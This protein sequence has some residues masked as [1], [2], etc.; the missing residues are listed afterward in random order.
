ML[1]S[2]AGGGPPSTC[3]GL[4]AEGTAMTGADELV[5]V[6]VEIH[7]AP[8]VRA[9][10]AEGGEGPL[11]GTHDPRRA[12]GRR[13]AEPTRPTDLEGGHRA[14]RCHP[15]RSGR[16]VWTG[17]VRSSLSAGRR[18]SC[19]RGLAGGAANAVRGPG[20][21]PTEYAA[22][23]GCEAAQQHRQQTRGQHNSAFELLR[24]QITGRRVVSAE[25]R[26]ALNDPAV[27]GTARP[28][29]QPR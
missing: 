9:H 4:G 13:V 20:S 14:H 2:G 12:P 11:T 24:C 8:G 16:P 26:R 10:G 15:G 3:P 28:P 7:G 18:G 29:H 5:A 23:Q 17:T 21:T 25:G 19:L 6:R 27:K 22:E 1:P